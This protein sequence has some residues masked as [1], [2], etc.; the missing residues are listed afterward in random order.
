MGARRKGL[1]NGSKGMGLVF[2]TEL[3]GRSNR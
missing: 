3:C 2:T 1:V